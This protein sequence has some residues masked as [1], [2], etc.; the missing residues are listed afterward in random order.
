L[1]QL[2]AGGGSIHDAHNAPPPASQ[3]PPVAAGP[4]LFNFTYRIDDY[5]NCSPVLMLAKCKLLFVYKKQMR[6]EV[7]RAQRAADHP[8]LNQIFAVVEIHRRHR[9]AA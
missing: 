6:L 7:A 3:R 1:S 5:R 4:R 9:P 8:D 2:Q